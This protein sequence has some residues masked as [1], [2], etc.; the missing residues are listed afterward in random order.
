MP[1]A[2]DD[3]DIKFGKAGVGF[4]EVNV[5]TEAGTL[6]GLCMFGEGDEGWGESFG[7]C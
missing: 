1:A 4:L 2:R 7:G 6:P 3:E 5:G